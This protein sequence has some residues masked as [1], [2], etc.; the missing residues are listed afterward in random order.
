M[1]REL[2]PQARDDVHV[3]R[4]PELADRL[5]EWSNRTSPATPDPAVDLTVTWVRIAPRH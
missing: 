4:C 5:A 1:T 2:T 3:Y